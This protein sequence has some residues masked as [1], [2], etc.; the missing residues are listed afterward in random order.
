MRRFSYLGS[1]SRWGSRNRA[2]VLTAATLWVAAG[3]VACAAPE[4]QAPEATAPEAT[5]AEEGEWVS[6]FN[7]KDLTGW[8][9][10][11]ADVWKVEGGVLVARSTGGDGSTLWHEGDFE[12]YEVSTTY[13]LEGENADSGVFLGGTEYQVQTG[14][15]GSR[16]VNLTGC[17]YY[18]GP[19]EGKGTYI[20]EYPKPEKKVRKDDWNDLLIRVEGQ[21]VR[22]TLNGE[23]VLDFTESEPTRKFEPGGKIGLQLH[24][25]LVMNVHFREIR[26]RTLSTEEKMESEEEEAAS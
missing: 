19:G 12:N 17:I 4:S 24:G 9:L 7:G 6:V 22:I 10:D 1:V 13:K 5:S 16:K 2:L 8:E 15:S 26:L 3:L 11:G 23:E 14:I 18:G 25:N 20:G 21:R